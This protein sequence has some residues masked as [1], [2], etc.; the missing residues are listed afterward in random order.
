MASLRSRLQRIHHQAATLEIRFSRKSQHIKAVITATII[1]TITW[2][3]FRRR[4]CCWRSG[5]P[6]SSL[7]EGA[8]NATQSRAT[9]CSYLQR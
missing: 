9:P 4:A 1:A 5:F 6:C 8:H 2:L 7:L 3:S